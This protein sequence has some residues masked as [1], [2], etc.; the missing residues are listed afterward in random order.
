MSQAK[1]DEMFG[2]DRFVDQT[3]EVVWC[4]VSHNRYGKSV[5][6]VIVVCPY[7]DSLHYRLEYG[8][9]AMAVCANFAD[10]LAAF[11]EMI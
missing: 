4:S 9:E 2:D 8:H 6:L 3:T 10:A 5:R 1:I 11:R 7:L